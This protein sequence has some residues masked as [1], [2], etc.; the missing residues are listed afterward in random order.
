MMDDTVRLFS[1]KIKAYMANTK[2]HASGKKGCKKYLLDF[3][4]GEKCVSL[5]VHV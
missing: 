1:Y 4:C 3:V 5:T 2:P